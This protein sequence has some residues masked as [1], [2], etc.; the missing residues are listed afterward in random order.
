MIA[1]R[2]FFLSFELLPRSGVQGRETLSAYILKIILFIEMSR[3]CN[4]LIGGV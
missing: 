4:A 2:F 1:Q 3:V